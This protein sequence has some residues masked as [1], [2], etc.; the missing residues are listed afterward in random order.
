MFKTND[1]RDRVSY[2]D[3]LI[4]PSGY[5]LN[6]AVGSTY[7]LDLEALTAVCIALGLNE[8]VDSSINQ[9]PIC[10][11]NALQNVSKRMLVF[12][13]A[14]QIKMNKS[15]SS[16]SLLLE[17]IIVPV[18]LKKCKE[19]IYPSFH[20]KT[21]V[22]EYVN[23]EG[24]Y[25]YRFAILSRNLTFDRSWDIC[26]SMDSTEKMNT[27]EKTKP[28]VCYLEFLKDQI[29]DTVQDK[30]EKIKAISRLCEAV[31]EV[32][33][34]TGSREFK[35]NFDILPLGIVNG[36]H[37]MNNDPLC[38]KSNSFH[39]L[40][41]FS[42]FVSGSLIESWNDDKRTLTGTKRTLI[43]RKS[44]LSRFTSA[45]SSNFNIYTLKD[46][47]IDGEDFISEENEE[48]Q[49]QDIHGKIY[50]R[51]KYN[52]VD[53]YLG[54][55]NA[56]HS[57]INRNVEMMIKLQ[58][59]QGKYSG[60][61]FLNE[62]FCGD[63]GGDQNPF[64]KSFP[65]TIANSEMQET[66]ELEKIIKD[67]CRMN[68]SAEVNKNN[69][70]YDVTL[71]VKGKI[72]NID[73]TITPFRLDKPVKLESTVV[74]S[75]LDILQL[76]DFYTVEIKGNN[77]TIQRIIM[78]KTKG[79]PKERD[80][81]VVNCII[82]DTKSFFE[83][84][85]YV[86]GDSYLVSFLEEKNAENQGGWSNENKVLLALYEK[87][88]RASFEDPEKINEISSVIDMITND[89]VIPDGFNELYDVFKKSIKQ[90]R[91]K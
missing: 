79:I 47:I 83:Y 14:G 66:K 2:S 45:Q 69:S 84:V 7:S 91:S 56:T 62:I 78:I 4:P 46:D 22:L 70:K 33:F 82:H 52:Y 31:K 81:N 90:R 13:E 51:R 28:L 88:L 54:S 8:N 41:V 6:F 42:P 58:T 25:L 5:A 55:M 86:L 59:T 48:K 37:D 77:S 57:A 16:L 53:L 29:K 80:S 32:S 3:V 40:V 39:D 49:K 15:P 72:P 64:E 18:A 12:C 19:G 35:E 24:K 34:T 36:K 74:F 20:P 87:M 68:M 10:M 30:N 60:E 9:N 1:K 50:I 11:L 65:T 85:S 67:I 71:T 76:S 38:C 63:E 21:W 75:Q 89:N 43:T 44:E 26:F 23:K 27:K 73:I 61:K 17:K